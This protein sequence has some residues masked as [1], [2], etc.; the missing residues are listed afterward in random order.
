MTDRAV[1]PDSD[2][3]RT[4]YTEALHEA[5]GG[6]FHGDVRFGGFADYAPG[7]FAKDRRALVPAS[8]RADRF[9]DLLEAVTD[10]D[11]EVKPFGGV[12]DLR[13]AYPMRIGDG[14]IFYRGDPDGTQFL[15]GED[16]KLFILPF[17]ALL[18]TLA[19]RVPG[20][21]RGRP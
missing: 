20:A 19:A 8:V 7:W 16:G 17:D 6:T 10:E 4:I 15:E 21:V 14:Y 18:P 11:L 5:A 3:A 2:E 9:D 1:D 12:G 13:S